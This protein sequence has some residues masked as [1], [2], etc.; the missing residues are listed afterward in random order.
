M[1]SGF[2]VQTTP[3]TI[4]GID[5]TPI[6]ASIVLNC[7]V[8]TSGLLTIHGKGSVITTQI[9]PKSI[10]NFAFAF[11]SFNEFSPWVLY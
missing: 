3:R 1:S 11:L 5:I 2:R 9:I 7:A 8:D 4:N 6:M 10:I